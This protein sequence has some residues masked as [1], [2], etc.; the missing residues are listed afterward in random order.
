[1]NEKISIVVFIL[2]NLK[3]SFEFFSEIYLQESDKILKYLI[4]SGQ[5]VVE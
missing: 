3:N 2:N 1:V 5:A 4:Q